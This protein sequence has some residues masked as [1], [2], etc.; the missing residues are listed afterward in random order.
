[1]HRL[2][3]EKSN[4]N[5]LT[6]CGTEEVLQSEIDAWS[7][8]EKVSAD[9]WKDTEKCGEEYRNSEQFYVRKIHGMANDA[10]RSDVIIAYR[11]CDIIGMALAEL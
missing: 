10:T 7:V 11:L 5:C 1:M 3:L 6:I 4:G 9:D 8:F 2:T